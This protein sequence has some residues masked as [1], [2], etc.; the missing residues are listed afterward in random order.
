LQGEELFLSQLQEPYRQQALE[1]IRSKL[2]DVDGFVAVSRYSAGYWIR[3]LGIAENQMHVVPLGIN[4]EGYSAADRA[5]QQPFRVGY[6]ARVAPEKGLHLLAESYLR[7]RRETDF[8]GAVLDV[9]GYLAPEHR[10]YLRGVE[11]R[12]KDAGF[13]AEFH[14]RGELDRPH[15]IEFLSSLHLLSVPCTYDEPKGIFLL[16]AMAA[17]VPV[18]QPRRGAFPEILEKTGGGL[19]VEPDDPA[20]LAVAIYR[21]WKAPEERAELLRESG[22]TA[23]WR[24]WRSGRSQPTRRFLPRWPMLEISQV[25]KQYPS[26]RGPLTVLSDVSLGLRRGEAAAIMGPSGAGKSTLLYIAGGLEPPTAGTVTLDGADPYQLG[27]KELAAF[28]NQKIGFVFQDHCLLP[29]CSVLENVLVPT[30][31]G[32]ADAEAPRRARELLD[33][34]GLADRIDHRPSEL[35]GGEKQRVALARALIRR[36]HLL[37][38]DEPTGNLDEASAEMVADLLMELHARQQTMLIVVTHSAALAARFPLR[39]EL[40]HANLYPAGA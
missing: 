35:S 32:D 15:K 26:A 7:L 13:G 37:L 31:V 10:A 38:C 27:E 36:P 34:V 16:E 28:R 21:L 39:Y 23:A 19:L 5:P 40:R 8:H 6:L 12:M 17:G 24:T 14:Y 33:Q 4:L 9:A 11:R 2:N 22:S 3:E 25:A 29:Q 18:V 20:S 1:L 30:L